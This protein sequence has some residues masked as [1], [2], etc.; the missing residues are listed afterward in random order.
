MGKRA[1]SLATFPPKGRKSRPFAPFPH[2]PRM[3]IWKWSLGL[4]KSFLMHSHSTALGEV[5]SKWKEFLTT[6]TFCCF[7]I[8]SVYRCIIFRSGKTIM[9]SLYSRDPTCDTHVIIQGP[10]SARLAQNEQSPISI[11][12]SESAG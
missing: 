7:S 3:R 1:C 6:L 5:L 11:R 4:H 12:N 2:P 8:R 9:F 10:V